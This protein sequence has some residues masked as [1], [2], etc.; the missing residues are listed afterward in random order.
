[1]SGC[2]VLG[3]RYDYG[4]GV[5]KDWAHAA[6]LYKQAC[7]GGDMNG[8]SAIGDMYANGKGV[9]KDRARALDLFKRACVAGWTSACSSFVFWAVEKKNDARAHTL[10]KQ[11]CDGEHGRLLQPRQNL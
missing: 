4:R 3:A 2:T 6:E 11:A 1:M 5:A 9:T 10:F 7:D 8:C